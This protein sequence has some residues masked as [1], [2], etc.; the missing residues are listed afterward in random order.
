MHFADL[1]DLVRRQEFYQKSEKENITKNPALDV[2]RNQKQQENVLI[3]NINLLIGS[4]A[5]PKLKLY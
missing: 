4:Y 5:F 3:N 2:K 1:K